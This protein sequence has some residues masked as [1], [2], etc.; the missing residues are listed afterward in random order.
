MALTRKKIFYVGISF[1]HFIIYRLHVRFSLSKLAPTGHYGVYHILASSFSF[2]N[3]S[4]LDSS[5]CLYSYKRLNR[6]NTQPIQGAS[7]K[8]YTESSVFSS[9]V[10]LFSFPF[11]FVWSRQRHQT[12][13]W[14]W[15]KTDVCDT[16]FRWNVP[17]KKK[18]CKSA[19]VR[20][21]LNC[22]WEWRRK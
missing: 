11:T 17:S 22:I 21:E 15:R 1:T 14:P 16:A 6:G 7:E 9:L 12:K 2:R 10:H 8:I 20:E 18:C 5:G 19:C 3:V 13:S 4:Q